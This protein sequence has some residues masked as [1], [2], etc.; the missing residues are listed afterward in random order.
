MKKEE[1]PHTVYRKRIISN[2]EKNSF[3]EKNALTI[4][5]NQ[6]ENVIIKN[7]KDNTTIEISFTNKI[8]KNRKNNKIFHRKTACIKS[9]KKQYIIKRIK[10]YRKEEKNDFNK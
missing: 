6:N 3:K 5:L 7:I 2:E 9:C 4:T 8:Y 1:Y 10:N